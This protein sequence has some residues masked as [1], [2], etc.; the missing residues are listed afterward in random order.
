M[1]FSTSLNTDNRVYLQSIVKGNWPGT[2][3]FYPIPDYFNT[4]EFL[5]Y[6][7]PVN[8]ELRIGF[9]LASQTGSSVSTIGLFVDDALRTI[10]PLRDNLFYALY[11]TI[12]INAGEVISVRFMPAGRGIDLSLVVGGH[13][14][15]HEERRFSS[16]GYGIREL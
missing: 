8:N 1:G 4:G 12:S 10:A 15:T 14:I 3:G 2:D 6:T 5:D 9:V 7:I 16:N 11:D 13:L